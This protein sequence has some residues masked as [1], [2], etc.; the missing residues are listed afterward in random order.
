MLKVMNGKLSLRTEHFLA[1]TVPTVSIELSL[2]AITTLLRSILNW[3]SPGLPRIR[4]S[5]RNT[6]FLLIQKSGGSVRTAT[7]GRLVLLTELR[8]MAVLTVPVTE[9][10]KATTILPQRIQS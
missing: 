5:L 9:S 3:L 6:L 8:D 2:R 1:A 4:K 10:G 7:N